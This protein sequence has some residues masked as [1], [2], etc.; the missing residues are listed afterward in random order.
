VD[1]HLYEAIGAVTEPISFT[2]TCFSYQAAW[3]GNYDIRDLAQTPSGSQLDEYAETKE[4]YDPKQTSTDEALQ[5]WMFRQ[6]SNMPIT[7]L[8]TFRML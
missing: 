8:K 4:I 5:P 3:K 7:A 6:V 1:V 2:A